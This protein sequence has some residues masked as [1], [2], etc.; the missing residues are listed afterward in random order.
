MR[1]KQLFLQPHCR[2]SKC[3]KLILLP[4]KYSIVLDIND[5]LAR[6]AEQVDALVSK[7][8][9][10]SRAG[11]IPAPGTISLFFSGID[12]KF[13]LHAGIKF[14]YHFPLFLKCINFI[15]PKKQL[16]LM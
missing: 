13:F 12:K 7:T 9:G 11:S 1:Q 2:Q 15:S 8:S 4:Q 5:T 14:S 6:M 16:K 10:I 3:K